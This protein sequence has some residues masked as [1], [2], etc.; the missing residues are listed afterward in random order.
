MVSLIKECVT[1]KD[2]SRGD[3]KDSLLPHRKRYN[4]LQ[5][6]TRAQAGSVFDIVFVLF[7]L[8]RERGIGVPV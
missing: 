4:C 7:F 8:E 2:L 3:S 1:L 6:H 5:L